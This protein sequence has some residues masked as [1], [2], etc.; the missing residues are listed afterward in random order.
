MPDP[1]QEGGGGLKGSDLGSAQLS[2]SRIIGASL[3]FAGSEVSP[4]YFNNCRSY[5]YM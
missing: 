4:S 1:R 5:E 3:F 2:Y